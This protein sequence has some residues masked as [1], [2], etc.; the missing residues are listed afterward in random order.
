MQGS[1]HGE[2]GSFSNDEFMLIYQRKLSGAA[3]NNDL[4]PDMRYGSLQTLIEQ[5]G[6]T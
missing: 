5:G 3:D 4:G 2:D 6:R 1:Y